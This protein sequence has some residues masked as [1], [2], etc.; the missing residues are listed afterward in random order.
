MTDKID[1]SLDDI[2]KK[3][4]GPGRGGGRGRGRGGRGAGGGG[5]GGGGAKRV[6]GGRG[7][8]G[9]SRGGPGGRGG[10]RG[11]GRGATRSPYVRGNADRSWDH[12]MFD[13]PRRGGIST[14]AATA[15]LVVSNLDF[16]VSN[17]DVTEL[18][19]EFGRLKNAVVHYDKSGRSLGSA[20]VIF[21]RKSDAIKAMKQYNGVP[22]DGRPMNIQLATSEVNPVGSRLGKSPMRRSFEGRRGGS[23]GAGG[24]V[25]KPARGAAVATRSPGRGNKRG[26]RGAGR[27]GRG[28]KKESAGP[29]PT[30]EDLDK[31]MD[32]YMKAK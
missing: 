25:G 21:E 11:G 20:D 26:G 24:R 3:T 27:G 28:A 17:N 7:A 5:R 13:G 15:K 29:P 10:R 19:S 6:P 1:Q 8:G 18:F 2:I 31:E 30:T 16:G 22:L 23:G 12:D 9:A 14:P 4:K 32:A